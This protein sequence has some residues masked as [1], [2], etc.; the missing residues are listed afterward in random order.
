MVRTHVRPLRR[1]VTLGIALLATWLAASGV[2]RAATEQE[3]IAKIVELNRD[4]VAQYQKKHFDAARKVLKQALE[5]CEQ[6]GLDHHPVAARTH[7][8]LGIVIVAGFGQREIG[9]R[10]FNEAL[11]IDPNITLT[12]GLATPVAEDVFNEALMAVSPK[13]APRAAAPVETPAPSD[14]PAAPPPAA[15]AGGRRGAPRAD[16]DAGR[17]R[18][19]ARRATRAGAR[20]AGRRRRRRRRRRR[21]RPRVA[22]PARRSRGRRRGLGQRHG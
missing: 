12:P 13:T 7:I 11:Q 21:A 3:T 6:S 14:A 5:L 16:F 17:G 22:H 15:P 4:G 19:S 2:A 8:H 1:S 20:E 18:C 9:S 10:Q